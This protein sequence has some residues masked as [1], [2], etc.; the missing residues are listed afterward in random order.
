MEVGVLER[1]ASMMRSQSSK[2]QGVIAVD[3][4][5]PKLKR[6]AGQLLA[7]ILMYRS[8]P[9][10][11]S[12]DKATAS[13]EFKISRVVGTVLP[14]RRVSV[15]KRQFGTVLASAHSGDLRSSRV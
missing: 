2:L 12:T 3:S 9:V 14:S 11:G 7:R 15:E 1:S 8:S 10:C 4:S 5:V 13:M 6:A